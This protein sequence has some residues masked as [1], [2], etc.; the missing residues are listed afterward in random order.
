MNF[1]SK[2]LHVYEA[3]GQRRRWHGPSF[4]AGAVVVEF[5]LVIPLIMLFALGIADFGRIAYFHQ[6]VCNASRTAAEVGAIHKFTSYTRTSWEND[7]YQAALAEMEH[8]PNFN[9]SE[10]QFTLS[11]TIDADGMAIINVSIS[12]P[13]RCNVPWPG[14]PTEVMLT[15]QSQFRQFR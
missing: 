13:F 6:V 15:K 14:L 12:Y 2:P 9:V 8:T 10:M 4:P 5:A 3:R 1:N 11:T 7:V